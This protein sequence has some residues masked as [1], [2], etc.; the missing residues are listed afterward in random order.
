MR[1][2]PLPDSQDPV[3]PGEALKFVQDL[4]RKFWKAYETRTGRE[5]LRKYLSKYEED[6]L[7]RVGRRVMIDIM[8]RPNPPQGSGG[9]A[10]PTGPTPPPVGKSGAG[11]KSDKTSGKTAGRPATTVK[12]KKATKQAARQGRKGVAKK[13]TAGRTPRKTRKS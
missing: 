10:A 6:Y 12:P 8:K 7:R 11:A 3:P 4:Q 2:K 9:K 1:R 5:K 13:S